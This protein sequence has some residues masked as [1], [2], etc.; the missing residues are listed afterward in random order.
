VNL[1]SRA[2]MAHDDLVV[3]RMFLAA[4]LQLDDDDTAT[5]QQVV[6]NLLGM[7]SELVAESVRR[8]SCPTC[9]GLGEHV[10]GCPEMDRPR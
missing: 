2:D 7:S 3:L 8:A 1:P 5:A 10:V 6:G 4:R 9:G